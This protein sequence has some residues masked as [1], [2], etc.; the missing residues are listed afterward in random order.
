MIQV[1]TSYGDFQ[2]RVTQTMVRPASAVRQADLERSQTEELILY[3]CYPFGTQLGEKTK[4][5]FV[6]CEKIY[7]PRLEDDSN[8]Q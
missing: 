8:E 7:G 6:T 5:L 2:Y 4:R 1:N 3:T